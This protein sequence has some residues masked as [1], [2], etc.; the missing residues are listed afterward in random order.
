[1]KLIFTV[2]REKVISLPLYQIFIIFNQSMCR[3]RE[4]VLLLIGLFISC[5]V[6]ILNIVALIV[7]QR[8]L[9]G[10]RCAI[11]VNHTLLGKKTFFPRNF[12]SSTKFLEKKNFFFDCFHSNICVGHELFL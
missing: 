9:K 3:A 7:R 8:K 5:K 4:Y 1:M 11:T 10:E 12:F 6:V 2:K